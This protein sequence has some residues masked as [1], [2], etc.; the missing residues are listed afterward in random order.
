MSDEATARAMVEK[1]R[2][3]GLA[4]LTTQD[5]D[6]LVSL[7]AAALAANTDAIR[8]THEMFEHVAN[9]CDDCEGDGEPCEVYVELAGKARQATIVAIRKGTP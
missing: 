9:G 6:L 5:T 4:V 2:V 8:A 1:F 3:K 7:I